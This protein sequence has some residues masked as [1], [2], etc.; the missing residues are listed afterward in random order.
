MKPMRMHLTPLIFAAWMLACG[1][2]STVNSPPQNQGAV[3]GA[4]IQAEMSKDGLPSL[5]AC[6]IKGDKVVWK[7]FTVSAM[8]LT[9][10]PRLRKLFTFSLRFPKP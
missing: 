5:A 3:F 6:I 8:S 9:R 10:K 1:E 4:A 7:I 2:K